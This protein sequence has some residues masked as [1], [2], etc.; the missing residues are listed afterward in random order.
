MKQCKNS[1]AGG[2]HRFYR[3]LNLNV[4]FLVLNN[5]GAPPPSFNLS[6][7]ER[8]EFQPKSE[9][10]YATD[11]NHPAKLCCRSAKNILTLEETSPVIKILLLRSLSH[12]PGNQST[13]RRLCQF[14]RFSQGT[15]QV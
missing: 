3:A 8:S 11:V 6:V 5:N 7:R 10:K 4:V 12:P 13:L 14:H 2:L 15:M 9:E 1:L